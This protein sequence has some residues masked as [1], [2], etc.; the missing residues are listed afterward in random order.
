VTSHAHRHQVPL[1]AV[2]SRHHSQAIAPGSQR[3]RPDR[4]PA[5]LNPSLFA[6]LNCLIQNPAEAAI[7]WRSLTTAATHVL[8]D[9]QGPLLPGRL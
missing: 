7:A 4:P 8:I 1:D 9:Q 2:R 3:I 6:P 5:R